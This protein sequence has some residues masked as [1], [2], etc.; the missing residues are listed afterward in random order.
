MD[1][2]FPLLTKD[3]IDIRIG[4]IS[5]SDPNK[6]S[7]LLYQDAR[8]GM[9]YLDKVVGPTNWQKRYYEAKGLL[10]CAVSIYDA[11]KKQWIEKCDTG[12]A[13]NIEEEKSIASDSFKRVCVNWGL[14]R[15]LYSAPDIWVKIKDKYDKFYVKEIAYDKN[16]EISKLIIVNG[17]GEIVYTFPKNAKSNDYA[18]KQEPKTVEQP[19]PSASNEKI[20]LEDYMLIS[21]YL[22]TA[23]DEDITKFNNY[24]IATYGKN[25]WKDLNANEGQLVAN[26]VRRKTNG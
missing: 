9:K 13:Q 10:I 24:I 21:N 16:E 25:D 14:A 20:A 3:D 19:K 12:S 23:S 1:I 6:A 2:K 11:E 18:P 8:C 5:K 15:E 22:M 26:Q 17:N 7:L 4:Q